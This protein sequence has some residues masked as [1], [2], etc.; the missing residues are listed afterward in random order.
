MES[1]AQWQPVACVYQADLRVHCMQASG[2]DMRKT[3]AHG[4]HV[5]MCLGG[6]RGGQ[7][8][9]GKQGTSS[10]TQ[11]LGRACSVCMCVTMHPI[12][13]AAASAM[14]TAYN[15]LRPCVAHVRTE[16][17]FLHPP[18]CPCK[19]YRHTSC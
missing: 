15:S 5:Y 1:M 6:G 18:V 16:H 13:K 3:C 4:Q 14:S 7:A 19:L 12:R 9:I 8:V 2:L 17:V 11:G 10:L